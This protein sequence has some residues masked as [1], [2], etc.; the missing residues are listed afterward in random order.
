MHKFLLSKTLFR[1]ISTYINANSLLTARDIQLIN[2]TRTDRREFQKILGLVDRLLRGEVMTCDEINQIQRH[3][4]LQRSRRLDDLKE[5]QKYNNER[6]KSQKIGLK[7]VNNQIHNL[8][9]NFKDEKQRLDKYRN[10]FISDIDKL[11]FQNAILKRYIE[12][13]PDSEEY[14]HILEKNILN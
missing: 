1:S 14:G 13:K 8:V 2:E 3:I 4:M 11:K 10:N 6:I 7:F 5:M 12:A 9:N